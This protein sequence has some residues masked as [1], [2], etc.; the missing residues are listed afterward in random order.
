MNKT[1][2]TMMILGVLMFASMSA[3]ASAIAVTSRNNVVQANVFNIAIVYSTGGLGDL[4]FN[5]AAKRGIDQAIAAHGADVVKVN[6][7][8]GET[9]CD[10]PDINA[11][12][13]QFGDE[14]KYDLIIG[15]GF[16]AF[17]GINA[18]AV[19]HPTQHYMIVD[20][21]FELDNVESIIFK[22][23]EA[24]F[25]VGLMA[26][27]ITKTKKFGFLGGL[28]IPLID[29]FGAGFVYGGQYIDENITALVTYAPNPD[30]PWGDTDGGKRVAQKFLEEGA[31]QIFA[32]AGGTGIGVIEAVADYNADAADKAYAIG[33]DSD[34]DHISKGN[35]LTS[36]LKNVD[37]AVNDSIASVINS[38]W[39]AGIKNM[40]Y[41][42]GY[43]DLSPMNFTKELRDGTYTNSKSKYDGMKRIDVI[44]AVKKDL[45]DGKITIA[46]DFKSL[47]GVEQIE[48]PT[49]GSFLPLPI[50]PTFFGLF[51]TAVILKRRK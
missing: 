35:V 34:Q 18:S 14:L 24:G 37:K 1:K 8:C 39:K 50:L 4:S 20:S 22:E 9:K 45:L 12:I 49:G 17:D 3:N 28:P 47:S 43:V 41:A 13:D 46:Q 19:E 42:E 6:E 11:A 33:V 26:G 27:M 25:L 23:E 21:K 32:A 16:S 10:F 5:D 40:G 36:A 44:N 7:A 31:D 29:R 51:V 38:A 30:N 15:I 2:I 48:V